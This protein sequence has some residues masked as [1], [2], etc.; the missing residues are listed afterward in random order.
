MI[1][2]I[3]II[4]FAISYFASMLAILGM[5]TIGPFWLCL[6]YGFGDWNWVSFLPI[7]LVTLSVILEK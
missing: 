1:K 7:V 3:I 5:M 6:T 4:L 2:K